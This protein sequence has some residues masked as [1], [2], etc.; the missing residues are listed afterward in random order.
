MIEIKSNIREQ[1][2]NTYCMWLDHWA[3]L[4]S[5]VSVNTNTSGQF[6]VCKERLKRSS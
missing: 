3:M 1:T 5:P 6:A 4:R 2:M